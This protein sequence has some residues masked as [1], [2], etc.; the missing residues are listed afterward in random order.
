MALRDFLS[1][2]YFGSFPY[3]KGKT[4]PDFF[5]TDIEDRNL[6]LISGKSF[7]ITC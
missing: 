5:K 2:L 4:I 3:Y 7:K 1:K 6:E